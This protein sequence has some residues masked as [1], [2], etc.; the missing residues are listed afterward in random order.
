LGGS[1]QHAPASTTDFSGYTYT[2]TPYYVDDNG[3]TAGAEAAPANAQLTWNSNAVIWDPAEDGTGTSIAYN[4]ASLSGGVVLNTLNPDIVIGAGYS[5]ASNPNS[6]ASPNLLTNAYNM[7][8]SG[9]FQAE[10]IYIKDGAPT[11]LS[12]TTVGARTIGADGIT[13]EATATSANF[14]TGNGTNGGAYPLNLAASQ[15][16]TNNNTAATG[17]LSV[18]VPINGAAPTA[19]TYTLTL[20]NNNTA[21]TATNNTFLVNGVISNGTAGGS[22]ALNVAS[23]AGTYV[24]LSPYANIVTA[25]T[26]TS[27][28]TYS[29]GTN[30]LGGILDATSASAL[31]TGNVTI[32]PSG[33]AA[34]ELEMDV[35]TV[36]T[37][38]QSLTLTD[39]GPALASAFL[40]Y[41]GT[42]TIS[43]LT[44]DG[45]PFAPGVYGPGAGGTPESFLTGT[46]TLTVVPEPASLG[47]VGFG[48]LG[49]IRRRR[50]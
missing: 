13:L 17:T 50:K 18:S 30:I 48:A 8:I 5:N 42:D 25:P 43:A 2:N 37:A 45:V 24:T 6:V 10:G 3:A 33:T 15:T 20:A 44:D 47:F 16:W 7:I 34:A 31:G 35:N 32:A 1:H 28:S 26:V 4:N 29:G 39:N 41:T 49:L 36:L 22:L 12:G 27:P 38:T 9:A 46:G 14:K 19:T 21:S 23:A 40:N 11:L